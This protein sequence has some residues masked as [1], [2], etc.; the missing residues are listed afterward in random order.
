[1]SGNNL[2]RKE[3]R[4]EKR[5]SGTLRGK[6]RRSAVPFNRGILPEAFPSVPQRVKKPRRVCRPQAA[7]GF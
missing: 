5:G 2:A 7:K 4:K 1:M 3:K 6:L